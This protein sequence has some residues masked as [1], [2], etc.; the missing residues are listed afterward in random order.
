M[1]EVILVAY[2]AK[3]GSEIWVYDFVSKMFLAKHLL[4]KT[5]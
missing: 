5:P 4:K 1:E 3:K 2:I